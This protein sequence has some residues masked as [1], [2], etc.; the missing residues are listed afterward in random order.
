MRSSVASR[1]RIGPTQHRP[2]GGGK[3]FEARRRSACYHTSAGS[4]AC[5]RKTGQGTGLG[6]RFQGAKS[7]SHSTLRWRK[8]DSN[9]YRAFPVKWLFW[10]VAGCSL[11]GAGKPFFIPSPAIRFP[12]RAEGVKGPKR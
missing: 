4:S 6:E 5:Q 7:G 2:I 12:E 10:V 1:N 11:F 9:L 3:G 8:G